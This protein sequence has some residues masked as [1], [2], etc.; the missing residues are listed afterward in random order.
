VINELNRRNSG[1][2]SGSGE[3]EGEGAEGEGADILAILTL[4]TPV[5]GS[6]LNLTTSVTDTNSVVVTPTVAKVG[7][8]ISA[9]NSSSTMSL[10][11]YLAAS[12]LV[13]DSESD[14][15]WFGDLAT[16]VAQQW[17]S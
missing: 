6:A 12:N 3:G 16:D 1:A 15:D 10:E 9:A 17:L 4:G 13:E 5:T 11:D 2:I 14:E 7:P 8:V